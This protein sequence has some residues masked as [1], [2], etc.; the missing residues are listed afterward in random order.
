MVT[1]RELI[2]QGWAAD[3][4]AR[5]KR[6]MDRMA[7]EIDALTNGAID[8]YSAPDWDFAAAYENGTEAHEAAREWLADLYPNKEF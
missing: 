1:T 8:M 7:Y 4:A 2:A 5:F 3:E 6:F